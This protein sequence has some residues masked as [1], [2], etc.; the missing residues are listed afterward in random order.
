MVNFQFTKRRWHNDEPFVGNIWVVN[1]LY[2]EFKNCEVKFEVKDDAGKVLNSQ[3]FDIK[4]IE[5]NSAKS[6]FSI[7]EDLLASVKEKFYVT[8]EMKDKDG[9]V[10]SAND[11]F[12]LIGDQQE[13]TKYY[14]E[15]EKE[16]VKQ[17]N[18]HGRY[19]SYYHFFKE[20]TGQDGAKY[21]SGNQI[22]RAIG[23]E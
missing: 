11:Y 5:E 3:S 1:D 17:E 21:E 23:F 19:G 2:E 4:K 20:F 10:I 9:K 7:K 18:L 22:P 16:R 12:F 6:F 13:A 14:N 15:W 8:L